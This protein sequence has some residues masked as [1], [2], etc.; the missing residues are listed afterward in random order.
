MTE[1]YV[2]YLPKAPSGIAR[3]M[4]AVIVVLFVAATTCAVGF[5]AF[6][7]TY[8]RSFFESGKER[9]FEGV[10]EA[11]PYPTLLSSPD[12]A[13]SSPLRYLLVA[14]G[15]HGADNQV[16]AYIGKRVRLRGR[17]IYRDDQKM[18]TLSGGSVAVLGDA[19]PNQAVPKNLGEFDLVGEIVDSKCYLGNMNP[20]NGKVHRDCAVRCLSGGIPPVFATNDFNGSPAVLQLTGPNQNGLPREAFLDRVAQPMR[21]HGKVM[22]I[23]NTLLL[24]TESSAIASRSFRRAPEQG[25]RRSMTISGR[26]QHSGLHTARR[27]CRQKP[28]QRDTFL[29]R[30]VTNWTRSPL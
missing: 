24:E 29:T 10:I 17:L 2:G 18:I 23:G 1:F 21:I 15:K 30:R 6:Q 13:N 5:A 4:K 19:Q 20:G 27:I 22:Q 26:T 3:K 28:A 11:G 16:D 14:N 7:R 9:T 8:A 12:V 25:D